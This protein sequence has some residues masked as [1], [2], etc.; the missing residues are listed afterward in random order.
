[1]F[2][3]SWLCHLSRHCF[4]VLPFSF[5]PINPQCRTPC[6][7]TSCTIKASYNSKIRKS[8]EFNTENKSNYLLWRPLPHHSFLHIRRSL[9]RNHI[10]VVIHISRFL[11]KWSGRILFSRASPVTVLGILKGQT[12]KQGTDL[13]VLLGICRYLQRVPPPPPP[14]LARCRF[15]DSTAVTSP[16]PAYD[17]QFE[18]TRRRKLM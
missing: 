16:G 15:R 11:C 3:S 1:M 8:A 5:D 9:V 17:P 18:V 12:E 10:M 13:Q 4:P 14:S 6:S 7:C 2:G